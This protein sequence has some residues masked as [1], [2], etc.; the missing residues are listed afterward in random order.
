MG[1]RQLVLQAPNER[2]KLFLASHAKHIGYG[3]A[4][5]GGKSWAVRDKA[6]RLC[7]NFGGIK[8]LIVRRTY[9]ELVN[10][11]INQLRDELNGIAKYNKSE[12][13][14]TFPN[15]S[16]IKFGYCNNDK[17][18]DQY[19]GAE[20]DVIF[21]DEA[22]QLQ[23]MWIKKITACV[24]GVNSFPK[25]IYYT[26]NPGGVSHGYIK[27]L[28]IDKQYESGEV[29]T[30]YE[31]IQALVTDNKALMESQP[32][33]IKQLE[34]LPPKLREAWL[35]GRWDIFEGQFFEDFRLT[36]DIDLCA[37]AG[38]TVEEALEQRRFTHVIEPFEPPRG[39]NIMRSYD[40]GYNKPFSLGYWAVDYDGVL[41]RIMEMYGCTQ[42]P[43]EGVKWS[44]DEQFRRIC[45][46]EREHPWLKNRKI[47]DSVAD[48]AIWDSSRGESIAETAM[49]YG[50]YFSPGDNER[51][52]GWMQVHY[53]FQ[54]DDN[55][56]PRMYFFN[57][58]KAAIRTI[59]LMMY[60]E[61][62]PEDLDTKLEDHCPDEIRYMCMS[63]PIQ[64]I[65]HKA[66]RTIIS[67]PL[68]QFTDTQR[69]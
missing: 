27:R 56:Y 66:P 21:L 59:P 13:I 14:F 34:A 40:F 29:P 19:Q 63:R 38:I 45:E 50:I 6:K 39:W 47:V 24:R 33:Y 5:G 67:D 25:R 54:F 31:F 23:E 36:P 41:Y 68:N 26:C 11:H 46:F 55:G 49:K 17:D 28:F 22:T 48:P 16:T 65:V 12:K 10:N 4:R 30:D 9:P 60:S 3:G 35:Y 20:Y 52:P 57:N 58:C 51:I 1:R 8:V 61:T 18:L 42:T 64:P 15:G 43:D 2:Q 32:D 53:R 62:K 7:L 44:P 69:Y 37:K